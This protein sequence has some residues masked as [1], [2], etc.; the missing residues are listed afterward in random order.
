MADECKSPM[1]SAR[2]PRTLVE[3]VDFV[4][5]NIDSGVDNRSKAI[6]AALEAWLPEMENRLVKLG[7]LE[8]THARRD[9]A[10][11]GA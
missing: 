5:R 6:K 4:T 3:R 1:V 7:I 10:K 11:Y 2:L 8:K 9:P